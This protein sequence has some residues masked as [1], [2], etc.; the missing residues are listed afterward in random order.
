MGGLNKLLVVMLVM[1]FGAY[2]IDP[3]NTATLAITTP[4]YSASV[5]SLGNLLPLLMM[6]TIVFVVF[7]GFGE[8]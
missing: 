1:V 2:L 3:V 5:A 8:V 7:K 6:V 4:T